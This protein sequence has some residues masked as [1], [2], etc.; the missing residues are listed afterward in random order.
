MAECKI[1]EG[2]EEFRSETG[3]EQDAMSYLYMKHMAKHLEDATEKGQSAFGKGDKYWKWFRFDR[4]SVT[5]MSASKITRG[6]S[7]ILYEGLG[8]KG[9]DWVRAKTMT[10]HKTFELNKI[11]TQYYKAWTTEYDAWLKEK[12]YKG[13]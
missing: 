2:V 9:K 8:R 10:Q 1:D 7:N 6:L 3:D 11:R 4:A 5:D 13:L 12:G